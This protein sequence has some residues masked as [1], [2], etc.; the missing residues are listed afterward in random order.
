M[1]QIRKFIKLPLIEKGLLFQSAFYLMAFWIALKI[2]PFKT[3]LAFVQ[4]IDSRKARA[5]VA[6]DRIIWGWKLSGGGFLL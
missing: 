4:D 3:L 5:K 1:G 2:V 6:P